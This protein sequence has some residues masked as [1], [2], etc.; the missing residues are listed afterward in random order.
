MANELAYRHTATGATVYATIR[1]AARTYWNGSALEALTV[2]NWANY[3]VVLTESPASSYFYVG[4]WP[5]L[6]TAAGFYYVDVY[7][8]ASGT[9]AIA[10]TL[11]GKLILYWNGSTAVPWDVNVVSTAVR[12]GAALS[13][14][15]F[16]MTL[17][18]TPVTSATVTA[19][20]SKDGGAF[21]GCSGLVTEVGNG[22]YKINLTA[23]EMTASIIALRFTA[24]GCDDLVI[25]LPVGV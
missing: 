18:R 16:A 21:T 14:L 8:Q 15:Y 25:T 19:T 7:A 24:S 9:P 20:I 23:T 6:L 4:T 11:A 12:Y 1:S 22:I 2:A 10:D 3:T 5:A 17:N 13:N